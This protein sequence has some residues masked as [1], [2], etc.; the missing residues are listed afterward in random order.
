[1]PVQRGEIGRITFGWLSI[2]MIYAYFFYAF[3]TFLVIMVG[4]ERI[5][6]LLNK[7]K[8]FDEYIYSIIFV[9]YLVPHFWIPYTG[10]GVAYE[11]CDYKNSWGSFQLHYYKITGNTFTI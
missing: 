7:S 3:T 8:R 9:I 6:I 10:W 11:V 2:P 1:M 5:D 4:H